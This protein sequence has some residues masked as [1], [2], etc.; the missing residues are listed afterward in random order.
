MII[1]RNMYGSITARNIE[2]GAEFTVCTPLAK[3]QGGRCL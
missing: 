2:E 1:E 3:E